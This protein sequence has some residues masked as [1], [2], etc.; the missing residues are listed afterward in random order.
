MARTA[1][2]DA[3]I[4]PATSAD[5]PA[6]LGLLAASDLPADGVE[7]HLAD[8]LVAV[9]D[10][11]LIGV[12]GVERYADGWLL[13]SVAVADSERG[14]GLG[15]ALT[16]RALERAAKAGASAV[17]LLTTTAEDWFPRWGFRRIGRDAVP[18]GVRQSVEFTGAC[19][20]TAAVMKLD[21]EETAHA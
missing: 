17:Y 18:A 15:A 2:V 16:T 12:A 1:V 21:L 13:R 11:A 10:G 19:P 4:R 7:A 8:F 5:A 14:R 9:R 20:A 6:V 3:T